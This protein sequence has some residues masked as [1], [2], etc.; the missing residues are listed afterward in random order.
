MLHGEGLSN[1][2]RSGF[3]VSDA[4]DINDD[5]IGDV[6][7]GAPGANRSYVLFGKDVASDG[8]FPADLN[9]SSLDGNNGFVTNGVSGA[10]GAGKVSGTGDI[11]HDGVSDLLIGAPGSDINGSRSGSAYVVFGQHIS[12]DEDKDGLLDS[13]DNCILQPNGPL[14]PDAGDHSQRDTDDDGYGNACDPDFDN[15]GTID[16]ADLAYL[17]SQFFTADPDADLDGNGSVD[18]AD[19]ATLKSMFFGP[20]GPS[21]LAP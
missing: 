11:N 14:I 4:G 12:A 8:N 10:D 3:S 20:P 18:F 5:G 13:S 7:I 6:V 19:L 17:K 2:D 15:N 9:L 16:F 1:R 21:G